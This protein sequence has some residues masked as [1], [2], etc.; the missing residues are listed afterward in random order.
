[1]SLLR[2]L[3]ELLHAE[4]QPFGQAELVSTYGQLPLEYAAIFRSA[5]L[6]DLPHRGVLEVTGEDRLA[7][8]NRLL[9]AELLARS[10]QA[11]EPGQGRFSFLLNNKGRLLAELNLLH[12]ANSTWLECDR[13]LLPE[14]LATLDRYLFREKVQLTIRDDLHELAILGRAAPAIIREIEGV[15]ITDWQPL[16]HAASTV[17][18]AEAILFTDSPTGTPGAF[19]L[20]GEQQAAS[21]WTHL[22]ERYYPAQPNEPR[23][24]VPIGW[25]AFNAAR[26]E[27][28][29]QLFGIDYDQTFLPAETGQLARAVSFTKGCYPGQEIVARMES[30]HQCARAIVGLRMASGHL[31]LSGAAVLDA[32]KRQVGTVTSSTISPRLANAALCLA[33]INKPHYEPGTEVLV[34]AEGELRAATVTTTPF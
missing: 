27:A 26:I 32:E 11:M 19:L 5:G 15:D 14:L 20:A 7:F 23:R 28:G 18:G 13:H 1:M 25:A 22:L 31:P 2:P 12:G 16:Q 4:F 33:A 9:T 34:A 10:R 6:M 21:M 8:L 29:R 17:A 30:H 3:H 24:L